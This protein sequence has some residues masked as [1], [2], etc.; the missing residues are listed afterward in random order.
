MKKKKKGQEEFRDRNKLVAVGL[1]ESKN[2]LL[3]CLN[4]LLHCFEHSNDIV[5]PCL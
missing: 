3:I 1:V 4:S 5:Q 2:A